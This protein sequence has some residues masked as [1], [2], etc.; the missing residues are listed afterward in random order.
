MNRFSRFALL[1]ALLLSFVACSTRRNLQYVTLSYYEHNAGCDGCP[2]VRV[3]LQSGGHVVYTGLSG[4]GVPGERNYRIPEGSFRELVRAFD[5]ANFFRIP[6]LDTR[7][8]WLDALV[9]RLAFKD[10]RRIHEVVDVNRQ[11]PRLT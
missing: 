5:D 1:S 7:R 3:D 6:R 8:V 2:E 9:I 10:E 11:I 4:C